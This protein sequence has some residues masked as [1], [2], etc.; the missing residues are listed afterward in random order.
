[1]AAVLD[2]FSIGSIVWCRTCYNTE[3][4]GEVMAFDPQV[5]ILILSIL[6]LVSEGC[7]LNLG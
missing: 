3:I 1:M 4:E 6:L 5:K 7:V 2:Y